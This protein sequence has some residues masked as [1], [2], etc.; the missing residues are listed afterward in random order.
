MFARNIVF[1]SFATDLDERKIS[2]NANQKDK[3]T[4]C[5][6]STKTKKKARYRG[7][8][9]S[10]T[11]APPIKR[12]HLYRKPVLLEPYKQRWRRGKTTLTMHTN[13]P[14]ARTTAS[15][16]KEHPTFSEWAIKNPESS[17]YIIIIVVNHILTQKV[18]NHYPTHQPTAH[19][20]K[21]STG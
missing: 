16:K 2:T 12:V 5:R 1:Q 8:L 3:A 14:N 20:T 17:P 6:E 10:S 15:K 4:S 7:V 13:E 9:S 19:S 18:A 11:V 21:S